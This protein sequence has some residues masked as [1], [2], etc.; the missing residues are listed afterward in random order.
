MRQIEL[1]HKHSK[2]SSLSNSLSFTKP[3]AVASNQAQD[4]N[5]DKCETRILLFI[6]QEYW[7]LGIGLEQV[8]CLKISYWNLDLF[9]GSKILPIVCG[10][11]TQRSHISIGF[12]LDLLDNIATGDTRIEKYR[13]KT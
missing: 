9:F 10:R 13:R 7:P 3:R 11:L 1:E 5:V 2:L 12:L 6:V 4:I 8:T